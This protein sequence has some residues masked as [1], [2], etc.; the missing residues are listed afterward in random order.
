MEEKILRLIDDGLDL[1]G[2]DSEGQ[3]AG[4]SDKLKQWLSCWVD[5]GMARADRGNGHMMV[6][7]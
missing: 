3:P 7:M 4:F 5:H 1:D 2:D 6:A